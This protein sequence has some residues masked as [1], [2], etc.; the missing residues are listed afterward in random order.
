MA[1]FAQLDENNI[2]VNVLVVANE[3]TQDENGVE[4]ETVG[5]Q[6]LQNLFQTT[7]VFVQTS[8]NE[9]FR[10]SY[11][12]IGGHYD[13]QLDAFFSEQPYASWIKDASL[14]RWVPPVD[15]P[16]PQSPNGIMSWNEEDLTWDEYIY[17]EQ[18]QD[19]IKFVA[20][21]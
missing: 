12:T 7:D 10:G 17:D 14:L 16:A 1:H 21:L 3:D 13:P 2:V 18:I 11:A 19:H 5:V 9:N 15:C 20:E 4:Q 8:Y 6:F